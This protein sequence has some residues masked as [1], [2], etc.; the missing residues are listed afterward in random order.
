MYLALVAVFMVLGVVPGALAYRLLCGTV[1][2]LQDA[3]ARLYADN[4]RLTEALVRKEGGFVDFAPK[5]ALPD[6]SKYG[7]TGTVGSPFWKSREPIK[8]TAEN[9]VVTAKR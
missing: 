1:K 2:S 5:F 3:N 9:G 7:P 4:Q 6:I 8:V